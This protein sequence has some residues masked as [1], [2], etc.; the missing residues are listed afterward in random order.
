MKRL[1]FL[2]TLL[3][4]I[5][6]SASIVY[7]VMEFYQPKQRPMAPV[8][9]ARIAE[10]SAEAAAT[11]FGGQ[12]SAIVISSYKLTGVI[13]SGREGVAILLADGQ[14]PRAV[15][16]GKQIASGVVLK[17]VW[18][19]YVMLSEGGVLKRIDIATDPTAGGGMGLA[20]PTAD[21]F[22]QQQQQQQQDQ[23][24]Q[25]MMQQQQM[26]QQQQ[27]QMQQPTPVPVLPGTSVP[28]P[29]NQPME[30]PPQQALPPGVPPPP[31]PAQMPQPTR[32]FSTGQG[33]V[34]NQ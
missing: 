34:P 15:Q 14:P 23:Q 33:N 11:L 17:E 29:S 7:W 8:V 21:Q 1:P 28:V 22:G 3:A 31:P 20:P 16:V 6:L 26:Q 24:Q 27:A 10:P 9:A 30:V 2:F 5:A 12:A 13:S 32:S 25:I 19:K 18:P 4:V